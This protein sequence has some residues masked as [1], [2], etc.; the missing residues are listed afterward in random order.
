[1]T[2]P[3]TCS[4]IVLG[5]LIPSSTNSMSY[6]SYSHPPSS[7]SS[8]APRGNSNY[9]TLANSVPS[10]R[11]ASALSLLACS[12]RAVSGIMPIW[13]LQMGGRPCWI[14]LGWVRLVMFYSRSLINLS[15]RQSHRIH[16]ITHATSSARSSHH[17]SFSCCYD[18][19]VRSHLCARGDQCGHPGHARLNT[20]K[21]SRVYRLTR[22]PSV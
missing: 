14:L 19:C 11:C 2:R 17:H 6:P 4:L 21:R 5:S 3:Q 9:H 8:F 10:A 20:F 16:T 7:P 18:N 1:M 15:R 13:V 22:S 12:M